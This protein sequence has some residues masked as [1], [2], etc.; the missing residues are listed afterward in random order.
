MSGISQREKLQLEQPKNFLFCR[1][2]SAIQHV[3]IH[4]QRYWIR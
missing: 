1:V 3:K 4:G 2:D